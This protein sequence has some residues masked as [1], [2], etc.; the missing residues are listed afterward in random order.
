MNNID[1]LKRSIRQ[2]LGSEKQSGD[3]L[4]LF[5]TVH[6]VTRQGD[7]LL[8]SHVNEILKEEIPW[9]EKQTE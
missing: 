9:I 7:G 6:T 2:F 3:F 1:K 5:M 4:M 8:W